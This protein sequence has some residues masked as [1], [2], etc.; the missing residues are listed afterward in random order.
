MGG[1]VQQ[2]QQRVRAQPIPQAER[3][4]I[5]AETA[6]GSGSADTIHP[7]RLGQPGQAQQGR[8]GDS[9]QP[10]ELHHRHARAAPPVARHTRASSYAWLRPIRKICGRLLQ[11]EEIGSV[12]QT[13]RYLPADR[14]E[15]G[16]T[17]SDHN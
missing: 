11:G 5:Q 3:S 17:A 12:H 13:H 1:Q 2:D 8:F 15:P 10:A 4:G 9:Q 6:A 7:G 14:H 16:L